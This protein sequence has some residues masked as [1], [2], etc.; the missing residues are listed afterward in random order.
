M[1]EIVTMVEFLM[2]R[3]KSAIQEL[4]MEHTPHLRRCVVDGHVSFS[5]LRSVTKVEFLML[6]L[7]SAIQELRMEHTPH[8]RRCVVDGHVSFSD[9]RSVVRELASVWDFVRDFVRFTASSHIQSSTG[10]VSQL[11]ISAIR[12][13]L[14]DELLYFGQ[15]CH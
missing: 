10:R 14:V 12:V 1:L 4:R 3:L 5:D 13:R 9:L 6:R 7:K 8:S 2:L 11:D 15:F